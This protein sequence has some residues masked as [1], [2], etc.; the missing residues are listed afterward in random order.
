MA[1]GIAGL[2][3]LMAPAKA[4]AFADNYRPFRFDLG[5]LY[6]FVHAGPGHGG[7]VVLEPMFNLTDRLSIGLRQEV[8]FARTTT[9]ESDPTAVVLQAKAWI[10]TSYL[11]KGEYYFTRGAIRPFASLAAGVYLNAGGS[12]EGVAHLGLAP[13]V[14]VELGVVRLSILYEAVFG[15][16]ASG[17][18]ITKGAVTQPD[19]GPSVNYLAFE[20]SFRIGGGARSPAFQ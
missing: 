12:D 13:Q 10:Q 1:A 20:L 9:R 2:G 4:L 19:S 15:A 8:L 7:G 16:H 11:A 6:G 3:L 5:G 18:E 17:V 14:G